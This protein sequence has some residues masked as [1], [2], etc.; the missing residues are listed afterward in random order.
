MPKARIFRPA[1]NAMQSGL[2]KTKSWLLV[3]EPAAN[4][5]PEPLMGWNT[6]KD[7]TRQVRLRF[8][9]ELKAIEYAQKQGL[10]FEIIEPHTPA[11]K[12][13]SYA[14]NFRFDRIKA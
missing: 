7:T 4:Q 8:P 9:S 10:E 12:P 3:W 11:F 1:K 14:D 13:K 6:Q 5:A 2:A